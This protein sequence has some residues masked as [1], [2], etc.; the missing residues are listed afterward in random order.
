[1]RTVPLL[2][3]LLGS[4][5][6]VANEMSPQDKPSP[7]AAIGGVVRARV[8]GETVS[9]R[10]DAK[11]CAV[12][13]RVSGGTTELDIPLRKVA[14]SMTTEKRGADSQIVVTARCSSKDHLCITGTTAAASSSREPVVQPRYAFR[15]AAAAVEAR[16]RFG[17][18]KKLTAHC[19]PLTKP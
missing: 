5:L 15:L 2:A 3:V 1:M 16:K 18:L 9:A 12:R 6:A 14:W 19:T 13:I 8:N 7:F 17:E 11:A 10:F 4:S